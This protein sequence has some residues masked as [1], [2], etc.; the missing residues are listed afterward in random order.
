MLIEAAAGNHDSDAQA[1]AAPISGSI[2]ADR[3][4]AWSN[5]CWPP[6]ARAHSGQHRCGGVVMARTTVLERVEHVECRCVH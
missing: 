3:S 6:R 2:R 4:A 1:L 5:A